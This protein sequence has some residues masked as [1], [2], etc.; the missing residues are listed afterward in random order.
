MKRPK[1][2]FPTFGHTQLANLRLIQVKAI[3]SVVYFGKFTSH[4]DNLRQSLVVVAAQS[5]IAFDLDMSNAD[6]L[7]SRDP[8]R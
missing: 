6:P 7:A 8:R 1:V 5:C 2:G 4:S 3:A